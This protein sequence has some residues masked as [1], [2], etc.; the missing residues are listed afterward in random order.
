MALSGRLARGKSSILTVLAALVVGAALHAGLSGDFPAAAQQ[1]GIPPALARGAI[2]A[3]FAELVEKLSTSVVNIRVT[4]A[5]RSRG[6]F[7]GPGEVLP[8]EPRERSLQAQEPRPRR[9]AGSGFIVNKSGLIVT[10]NHVV[11]GASEVLVILTSK[12]EHPAKVIGRDPKTDVALVKI[13]AKG[14]LPVAALGDSDALRVGDWVLAI[15]NPFGLANTVTAGIVS[16]KDRRIGAGPY[17]DFI[18]TDASINP[19]NSGGPLFNLQGE[20]VGINT[21]T[22]GQGIGFA[23]PVN[24]AKSLLPQLERT[25]Q[26]TRGWLGVGIQ[27]IGRDLARG[28]E[29]PDRK[30]ALVTSVMK[31]GPAAQAGL[32]RGDVI[33]KFNGRDIVEVDDLPAAVAGTTPDTQAAVLV[34]RDGKEQTVQVKVGTMPAERPERAE[35]PEP[36][37]QQQGRWGIGLGELDAETA[38]KLGLSPKEGVLVTS[39]QPGSP[40]EAAGLRADDVILEVNKQKVSSVKEAQEH[41]KTPGKDRPLVL[42]L[43]RGEST[44]YAALQ[45]N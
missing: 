20:V 36:S 4:K 40:A 8:S 1:A 13:E 41:A 7:M 33:L 16:A 12:E 30:G 10:N 3:S 29:L 32:K 15:G 2:P 22:R 45:P 17:D 34:R 28:L 6:P 25:G 23:V 5:E 38:Q 24:L 14:D 35:A 9:G 11:E 42:L 26:V 43:R 19:G 21:A 44:L 37:P 31:D 18:Q 39:V 27:G